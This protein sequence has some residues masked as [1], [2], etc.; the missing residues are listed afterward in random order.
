[1]VPTQPHLPISRINRYAQTIF[2]TLNQ[3]PRGCPRSPS[4]L[5]LVAT[6]YCSSRE[7]L[8]ASCAPDLLVEMKAEVRSGVI[9]VKIGSLN[10]PSREP[11]VIIHRVVQRFVDR[12][13]RTLA[14]QNTA[15]LADEI[16]LQQRQRYECAAGDT[17]PCTPSRGGGFRFP[18]RRRYRSVRSAIASANFPPNAPATRA[19]TPP[20]HTIITVQPRDDFPRSPVPSPLLIA[21]PWP[22]SFSLVQRT[23]GSARDLR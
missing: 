9:D 23:R 10:F 20:A 14:L 19:T 17:S 3:E 22:R 18:I 12:R 13:F 2:S 11:K 5:L 16:F 6:R 21:S 15:G 4:G 8:P 7:L 1:M